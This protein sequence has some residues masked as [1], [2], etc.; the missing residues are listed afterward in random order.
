M[1][2]SHLLTRSP[3]LI[4]LSGFVL[5]HVLALTLSL[6]GWFHPTLIFLAGVFLFGGFSFALFALYREHDW[7]RAKEAWAK[8]AKLVP[9]DPQVDQIRKVLH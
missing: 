5:A 6:F 7:V 1:I 9:S 3:W 2:F 8:A 4:A